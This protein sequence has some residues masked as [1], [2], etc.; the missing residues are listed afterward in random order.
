MKECKTINYYNS[1]AKEFVSGTVSVDFE[2]I[3]KKFTDRLPEK[4][5]ILELAQVEKYDGIWACSS[6]LHLPLDDLTDVMS[7]MIIALKVMDCQPTEKPLFHNEGRFFH[8]SRERRQPNHR[9]LDKRGQ[10]LFSCQKTKKE[11]LRMADEKSKRSRQPS[12]TASDCQLTLFP[13]S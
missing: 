6:M 11:V 13:L 7:K 9:G 4:S 10:A 3:Q 5:V 8:R 12:K 1:N 2:S